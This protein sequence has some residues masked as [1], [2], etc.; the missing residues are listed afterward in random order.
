[1]PEWKSRAGLSRGHGKYIHK[2]TAVTAGDAVGFSES[3]VQTFNDLFKWAE[4]FRGLIVIGKSND[5]CDEYLPVFFN[6]ELLGGKRMSAVAIGN[7]S[8]CFAG[9]LLKLVKSHTHGEDA[10]TDI[11]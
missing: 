10:G 8:Q 5:L 3:T 6:L 7:G 9:G 2:S 11:P 4:F 1:M